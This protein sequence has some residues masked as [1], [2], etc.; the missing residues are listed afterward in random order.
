[1]VGALGFEPQKSHSPLFQNK[2]Q[3]R[4]PRFVDPWATHAFHN[5]RGSLS[6]L[7]VLQRQD[8]EEPKRN[9][10]EYFSSPSLFF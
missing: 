10:K 9:G 7:G 4:Q 6:T 3:N 5:T 1:M 8:D 2:N